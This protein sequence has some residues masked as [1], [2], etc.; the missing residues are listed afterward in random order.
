[1]HCMLP[2]WEFIIMSSPNVNSALSNITNVINQTLKA[3]IPTKIVYPSN[4]SKPWFTRELRLLIRKR[5]RHYKPWLKTKNINHKRL[6][7]KTR[8]LVQRKI[9]LAKQKYNEQFMNKVNVVKTSDLKY[10]KH[11]NQKWKPSRKHS[12]PFTGSD[13]DIFTWGATGGASFATRGAVNGL[14]R[15]SMQWHDVTRKI[16]GMPGKIWGV[17]GPPGTPLVPPL[18][19]QCEWKTYT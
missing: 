9:K 16:W 12:Y 18:P 15:T 13:P 2:L 5:S 11:L 14:C 3:F 1:M 10:W 4:K 7:N 19:I 6:C 8:N 17:S